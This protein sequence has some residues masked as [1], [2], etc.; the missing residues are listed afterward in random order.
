[1]PIKGHELDQPLNFENDSE[2][3]AESS[4]PVMV[5]RGNEW[6]P[7]HSTEPLDNTIPTEMGNTSSYDVGIRSNLHHDIMYRPI[8]CT[9]YDQAGNPKECTPDCERHN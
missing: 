8:S 7:L 4:S 6:M 9:C 5:T 1:M 2:V 3:F